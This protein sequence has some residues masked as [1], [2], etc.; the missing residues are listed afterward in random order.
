MPI[1][2]FDCVITYVELEFD[3][4]SLLVTV[5]FQ[6]SAE[7]V[8]HERHVRPVRASARL[9]Q[10][11]APFS[12]KFKR[13]YGGERVK[14]AYKRVNYSGADFA[15]SLPPLYSLSSPSYNSPSPAPLLCPSA[16]LIT[17][18]DLMALHSTGVHFQ[19]SLLN[20][21]TEDGNFDFDPNLSLRFQLSDDVIRSI[22]AKFSEA[23]SLST[24]DSSSREEQS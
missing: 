2:L 11:F 9:S 21:I 6:D 4:M 15:G 17:T 22:R 13:Y 7:G 12:K 20:E 19:A 8:R 10:S 16:P 1:T 24:E 23:S 5:A 3:G 14:K 18:S